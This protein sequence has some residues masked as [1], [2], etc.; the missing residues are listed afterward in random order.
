MTSAPDTPQLLVDAHA[1]VGEGPSWDALTAR[2]MWVDTNGRRV[3]QYDPVTHRGGVLLETPADVGAVVPRRQGGVAIAM[4]GVFATYDAGAT[5]PSMIIPIG[6]GRFATRM[7]DGKCD[8]QGR[9]GAGTAAYGLPPGSGSLY[10][11]DRDLTATRVLD[12]ITISNGLG[13]SPDGRTMYYIDT[14]TGGLDAFDF[15]PRSGGISNRRRLITV[16][17][18]RGDPD[19]LAVDGDG[20]LWVALWG[21][22]AVQRYEP[23]GRPDQLVNLPCRL[24]TSCAFGGVDL[25]E[26]F[27]TTASVGLTA[28]DLSA[29][30]GAGGL[31]SCHPRRTGLPTNPFAA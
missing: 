17:P 1:Q 18:G 29:Q 4:D 14:A 5:T 3:H 30:P 28:D 26:L 15:D 13:W 27:I 21:G 31:F 8:P 16:P 7:N 23:D 20:G 12:G 25:D 10:R 24:V 2:L 9:F 19:G 22:G 11:L 6:I